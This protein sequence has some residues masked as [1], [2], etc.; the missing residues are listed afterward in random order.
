MAPPPPVAAPAPSSAPAP[1]QR[2]APGSPEWN[3]LTTEQ[4]HEQLRGPENP[5]AR[6]HSPAREQREAAAAR[7]SGPQP[8]TAPPAAAEPAAA[9]STDEPLFAVG[10]FEVRESQLASMLERQ[11]IDDQRKATLPASPADYKLELP[12]DFKAPG[13]VE[14]KIDEAGNQA[15]FDALRTFAHSKGWD[16]QMLSEVL[17]IYASHQSAQEARLAEISRAEIAKVGANGP[18]R[19]DAVSRW[20]TGLVGAADA[21]PIRATLVTDAHLRFYEKLMSQQASQGAAS[22]SSQHRVAPDQNK[23]PGYDNMSFEQRRHAQDQAAARR[24]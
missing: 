18:Q 10:K 1:A 20:I 14:F 24:R 8:Q 11:A 2:V 9:T 16:N 7:A 4:R 3:A 21:K 19:V 6:G 17:G 12:A 13:G 5:R 23:I 15:T 22:F